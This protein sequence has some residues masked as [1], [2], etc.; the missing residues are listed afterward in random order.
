MQCPRFSIGN[1][2]DM[3]H[4]R[5]AKRDR[6]ID[7][8]PMRIHLRSDID[9]T[10]FT[11]NICRFGNPT[12]HFE[13]R[14]SRASRRPDRHRTPQGGRGSRKQD[15]RT[16]SD[17]ERRSESDHG[18]RNPNRHCLRRIR[19]ARRRQRPSPGPSHTA[20][21][22]LRLTCVQTNIIKGRWSV[23][24]SK[25]IGGISIRCTKEAQT[26]SLPDR[27]EFMQQARS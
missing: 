10:F 4:R 2:C 22:P 7:R 5:E 9:E 18:D 15:P 26:S 27:A 20:S 14:C 8:R 6:E 19:K 12:R 1:Q 25:T 24:F 13:G 11:R 23:H 3:N 16:G 21:V 17:F